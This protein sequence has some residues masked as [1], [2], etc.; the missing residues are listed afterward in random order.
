[1]AYSSVNIVKNSISINKV[2]G[3]MNKNV[4]KKINNLK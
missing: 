1:M 3:N 2:N 4:K